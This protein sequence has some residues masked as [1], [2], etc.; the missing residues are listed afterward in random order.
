MLKFNKKVQLQADLKGGLS[1]GIKHRQTSTC[2][3]K[4]VLYLCPGKR[5]CNNV[6]DKEYADLLPSHDKPNRKL[7][8]TRERKVIGDLL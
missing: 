5:N 1:W 6:K 4:D 8:T 7:Q 3:L 2:I